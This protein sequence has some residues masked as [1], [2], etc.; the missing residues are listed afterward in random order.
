MQSLRF[1]LVSWRH[2]CHVTR[3][4][5]EFRESPL[6]GTPVSRAREDHSERGGHLPLR[7]TVWRG[8]GGL[9]E[10]GREKT[11]L[12]LQPTSVCLRACEGRCE[13]VVTVRRRVTV[14]ASVGRLGIGTSGNNPFSCR[15]RARIGRCESA[16]AASCARI[17]IRESVADP[18]PT[19][20]VT[21]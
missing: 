15:S 18:E 8:C 10:P 5:G 13:S 2:P 4:W 6:H 19:R 16:P 3:V 11:I 7:V 21:V 20:R 12:F 17:G 1:S 9:R 14:L